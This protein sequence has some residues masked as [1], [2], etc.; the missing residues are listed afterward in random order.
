MPHKFGHLLKSFREN[1]RDPQRNC[2]PL[3]QKRLAELI[4]ARL[5]IQSWPHPQTVSDWERNQYQ[6]EANADRQLLLAIIGILVEYGGIQT[7]E[8][9][10][11]LLSAGGYAPLTRQEQAGILHPPPGGKVTGGAK[12]P[13]PHLSPIAWGESPD[14]SIFYGRQAELAQLTHWVAAESCRVVAILGMGGIGKTALATRLAYDLKGEF[15]AISWRSLRNGPPLEEILG[16]WLQFLAPQEQAVLPDRLDKRISQLL[17]C[18]RQRRCLLILDNTESI[19]QSG[20][21]AGHYRAGYEDYGQLIQRLGETSHQSCLLLTSREKPKELAW[22]EGGVAPV[23]ALSLLGLPPGDGRAILHVTGL[24]GSDENLTTL[25][26]RYS[27]N[28]LALKLVSEPIR[29]LFNGEVGDFLTEGEVVFGDIRDV[30]ERQFERLT[31]LEQELM[32]WL[33]IEREAVSPDKLHEN[34]VRPVSKRVLLEAL[35]ALRR[36]SLIE[37]NA[38]GFTQQNVLMEYMV[39]R[40]IEGVCG[41]ILQGKTGLLNTY[42]LLKAQARDYVRESQARLILKPVIDGLLDRWGQSTLAATLHEILSN[43]RAAHPHQPGYAGGNLLHLLIHLKSDLSRYDFSGLVMQQTYLQGVDLRNTNFA[44]VDW[45]KPVFT[46]TFGAV[47]TV[48]LSADG[49]L[50]AIGTAEGE[51]RL[52]RVADN[53][54][55]FACKGHTDWVRAV[56]F[57]PD[58][59]VLASSSDD[60]LVKLWDV[61][62]GQNIKILQGHIGRV[63]FTTFS[64]VGN[65]L[66][67][68]GEDN[69]IRLWEVET[70]QSL[71]IL[72]DQLDPAEAAPTDLN[73]HPIAFNPTGHLLVSGSSHQCLCLWDVETGERLKILQ[74]HTGWTGSIAFGPDGQTLASGGSDQTIKVW[75]INTGQCLKTLPCHTEI[76]MSL[77]FSPDGKI[78]ASAGNDNLVRLWDVAAGQC[79]H[80]L[81]G[82]MSWI[83]SIAFSPDGRTLVSGSDDR[84]VRMWNTDTGQCAVLLKG[85]TNPV[86]SVAFN[87]QGTVL[88]S[89]SDDHLVRLWDVATGACSQTLSGHTDRVRSVAFIPAGD[90]VASASDRTIGL[91]HAATGHLL[92]KLNGHTGHVRS[93]AFS[94]NG[95]TLASGA[96]DNVI[97]LWDIKTG[98]S[99]TV[100]EGHSSA[101]WAVDFCPATGNVLASGGSD[102]AIRLWAADRGQ[103]LGILQGHL[104]EIWS[105]AFHPKGTLLASSSSDQTIRLWDWE[106]GACLKVIRGHT[107]QVRS[108]A[109]CLEGQF[110]ASGSDDGTVKIWNT[111]TGQCVATL[112]EHTK[113]VWSVACSPAGPVL[114]SSSLDE[115]IKLWDI[116]SGQC[117]KTLRPDRPYERMN[118]TGVTGLTEAQTMS[119]H[120][121]G[122]IEEAG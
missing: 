49:K 96:E 28:P 122:A 121:L 56:A 54:Q 5:N 80:I 79:K 112:A 71:K 38:A 1:T 95:D 57:S 83:R 15:E 14:V 99:L 104:A 62:T 24:S 19:L 16:D 82:H 37:A 2:K 94:P 31:A 42:A 22:L 30:L 115:T 44:H 27:G 45:V 40:L 51:I 25:V 11:T 77:V 61:S 87:R 43:L 113:A 39:D 103:C 47:L 60:Q 84:T 85:Y 10:H 81:H 53:R 73:A 33:A 108:V 97:R 78:L 90:I 21:Q 70:G 76:I 100:L 23:R 4:G 98:V 117:L 106:T 89:G 32:F 12:P 20:G 48:A 91:W 59:R 26:E 17:D 116:Q 36:R 68:G 55:I 64:P 34:L 120:A 58:N 119:L 7:V 65:I 101:V 13:P 109:F 46:D 8:D 63:F 107:D 86:K 74:G 88:A 75:N 6:P 66:A 105:M 118:I 93:I 69:T 72:K 102:A 52:W 67:S 18:L 29:E 41:E 35:A 50:L 9:S 92:K 3:S 111:H 110:L 114:A